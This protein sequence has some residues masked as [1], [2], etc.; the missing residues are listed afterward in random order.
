M[1]R[2]RQQ[3]L[4]RRLDETATVVH[5]ASGLLGQ[6][7]SLMRQV[8]MIIGWLVLLAGSVR[9]LVDPPPALSPAHFL[10]PGAGAAAVVQGLFRTARRDPP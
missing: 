2:S 3:K 4:A 7:S 10:A 6:M 8:V 9:L 1:A 5:A